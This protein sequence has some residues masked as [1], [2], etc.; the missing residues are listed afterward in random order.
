MA[1]QRALLA[2]HSSSERQPTVVDMG[3]MAF[4]APAATRPWGGTQVHA[5]PSADPF[6]ASELD[7]PVACMCP[8]RMGRGLWGV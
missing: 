6:E 2:H 3:V 5:S 7:T 8:K 1:Q 4:G